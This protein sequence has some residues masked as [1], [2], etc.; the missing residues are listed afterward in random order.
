MFY[1]IWYN[2]DINLCHNF[3]SKKHTYKID[4]VLK[5]HT[6]IEQVVCGLTYDSRCLVY[7]PVEMLFVVDPRFKNSFLNKKN[8]IG[9]HITSMSLL[10]KMIKKDPNYK[11]VLDHDAITNYDEFENFGI[12]I[13]RFLDETRFINYFENKKMIHN[14]FDN[15]NKKMFL[16]FCYFNNFDKKYVKLYG[17]K[18]DYKLNFFKNQ[19][20][21][22]GDYNNVNTTNIDYMNRP[23]IENLLDITLFNK[24]N[25]V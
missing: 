20:I 10:H 14:L 9:K 24:K 17:E 16:S 8:M 21:N 22:P 2:H 7:D 11:I 23:C 12:E 1:D 3:E 5:A 13:N 4:I 15:M 25:A 6:S 18:Y 19:K